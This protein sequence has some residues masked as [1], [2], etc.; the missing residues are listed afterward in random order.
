[1][2]LEFDS[3]EEFQATQRAEILKQCW[4]PPQ[5]VEGEFPSTSEV[6]LSSAIVAIVA[7]CWVLTVHSLN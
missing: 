4:E 1:M 2:L 3:Y 6:L 7:E 5:W